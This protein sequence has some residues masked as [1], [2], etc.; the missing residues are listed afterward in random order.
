MRGTGAGP[1]LADSLV[2]DARAEG[3]R[4]VAL[5]PFVRAKARKHPQWADAFV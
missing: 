3:F 4:I 5:C 1:R 2:A